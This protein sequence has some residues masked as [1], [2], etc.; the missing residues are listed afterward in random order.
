MER[1]SIQ[2]VIKQAAPLVLGVVMLIVVIAWLSGAFETTIEPGLE[3]APRRMLDGR[4]TALVERVTRTDVDESVGTLKAATR[5]QVSAKVLARIEAM[6]VRAGDYVEAGDI[7]VRLDDDDLQA[8]VKQAEEALK[9]ARAHWDNMS[10]E[11][12]RARK[13]YEGRAMTRA[14]F[15]DQKARMEMAR[16]QY[17]RAKQELVEAKVRRS[18]AAVKAPRAGRIVDRLAQPGDMAR[19]GEP[20][21][22]QY[23]AASLRLEVPVPEALA[24]HLRKGRTLPVVIDAL[25]RTFEATIDEIVPQAHAQSRSFLVKVALPP[26]EDLYE[27]MFGRLLL[28][29]QKQAHLC[30]PAEAIQTIGQLEFVDVVHGDGGLERRYVKTGGPCRNGE[31]ELLSGAA[32]GERI[33]LFDGA[34]TDRR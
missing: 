20:L 32:A 6:P 8:R 31:V 17:A 24:V 7:V 15:D 30:V 29:A 11:F 27:G 23:D 22:V 26:D 4:R 13:L 5:S 28:P 34:G 21:L 10:A 33:I 2:W 1:P 18:Y 16:A 25:N 14:Q 19:P 9:A 3:P 12:G